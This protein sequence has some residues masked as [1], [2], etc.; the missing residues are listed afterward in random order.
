MKQNFLLDWFAALRVL[1]NSCRREW[2]LLRRGDFQRSLNHRIYPYFKENHVYLAANWGHYC[3][4]IYYRIC[5]WRSFKSEKWQCLN[6]TRRSSSLI[7][8]LFMSSFPTSKA[9]IH[10]NT[11]YQQETRSRSALNWQKN[12][13]TCPTRA[14]SSRQ[15]WKMALFPWC[16]FKAGM[17]SPLPTLGRKRLGHGSLHSKPCTPINAK[18]IIVTAHQE[19]HSGILC[20][21]SVPWSVAPKAPASC[22]HAQLCTTPHKGYFHRNTQLCLKCNY[23]RLT[24]RTDWDPGPWSWCQALS[25]C[26]KQTLSLKLFCSCLCH[27]AKLGGYLLY[28]HKITEF[29]GQNYHIG[30]GHQWN[31]VSASNLQHSH[32]VN[33]RN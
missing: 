5:K 12:W 13:V 26:P 6:C 30:A 4:E 20:Q 7:F 2:S 15:I 16:S 10:K 22:L 32:L 18:G 11:T 29:M 1:L 25:Y 28:F 24:G 23:H 27:P 19:P 8:L 3:A 14:Q 9:S 31:A 33:S 17:S 21:E